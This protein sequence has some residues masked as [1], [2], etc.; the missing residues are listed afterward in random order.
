MEE[1]GKTT[2]VCTVCPTGC[3]MTVMRGEHDIILVEGNLCKR[4]QVYAEAEITHPVRTLTT[5]VRLCGSDRPLLPV[6]TNQPV[7][8]DRMREIV[9]EINGMA[10]TAPISLGQV[11]VRNIVGTGADIVATGSAGAASVTR[12]F[13]KEY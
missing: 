4:G 13:A 3:E 8:R 10:F 1:Q 7:P 2:V 11:L 9:R 12:F 6:R 5:T